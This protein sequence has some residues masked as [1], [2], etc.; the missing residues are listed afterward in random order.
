[1]LHMHILPY[2]YVADI[3]SL[4]TGLAR[5]A[6]LIA[7]A[8]AEAPNA[9]LFDNGDFLHGSPLGDEI[10][11]M[12]SRETH[13]P[14]ARHPIVAAMMRLGYDAITLGNHDFDHGLDYLGKVLAAAP[15][16]VVSSNLSVLPIGRT[17]GPGPAPVAVPFAILER[18]LRDEAGETHP[19]R[20]GLIGFLPPGSLTGLHGSRYR[21]VLRDIPATARTL[22]P[23]LRASGADLVIALAHSGIADVDDT[24]GLENAVIPLAAVPGI[25]AIVSG[26]AH[27]VFPREGTGWPEP[28]DL[29]RGRVH[30]VP[31]VAPGFWGSHLGIID[32]TLTRDRPDARWHVA[33]A[34]SEA[35]PI[36]KR[37]PATGKV[38][39]EV[40]PD[41]GI[42]AMLERLHRHTMRE[43]RHTVGETRRRLHSFF[44]AV[45][46]APALDIVHRAM[47]WQADRSLAG[48]AHAHLPRLAST[49]PFKA[50]GLAGPDYFVDIPPGPISLT[51][52]AELYLYPNDLV[53]LR[54]D[55]A[56]LTE[57]LERAASLFAQ[58]VPG[59][60]DQILLPKTAP[61]YGFETVA[62]IDYAIDLSQPPRYA[63]DGNLA[64]PQARR[65]TGLALDGRPLD[66]G[67]EVLLATN[68]YRVIGGGGYPVPG[69]ENIAL[70]PP[71]GL[72]DIVAD[73][74]AATGPFEHSPLARWRFAPLPGASLRFRTAP[75]AA[76]LVQEAGPAISTTGELDENGF[77]IC[78]LD[79]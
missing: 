49:A 79:L 36:S 2:D 19:L 55:R 25:D 18:S 41:P 34:R 26:H 13:K 30:G 74:L 39:P 52:L 66:P 40:E 7:H 51:A 24:P 3:P 64:N 44:A 61:I 45:A 11:R 58:I 60:Q 71:L 77:L 38:R 37:D 6:A 57:W 78:R 56:G 75:Q 70:D 42:L 46:P 23:L 73:Y 65:I 48:T 17:T 4:T 32:L 33:A 54:L 53:I 76:A 62:G 27:Q 67:D 63:F 31:V 47:L 12:L 29:A 5:T 1:D 16:P 20:I 9:L 28:V 35:R 15:F 69:P 14:R 21:A 8:R 10:M 68:S 59:G 72:R 50:G 22:V 43:A